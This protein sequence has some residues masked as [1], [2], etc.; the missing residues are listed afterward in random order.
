MEYTFRYMWKKGVFQAGSC[1]KESKQD[2]QRHGDSRGCETSM[3]D[4]FIST[5]FSSVTNEAVSQ[6]D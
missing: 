1:V 4:P 3:E 2:I 5:S 6:E